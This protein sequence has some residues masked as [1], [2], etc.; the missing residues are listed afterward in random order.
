VVYALLRYGLGFGKFERQFPAAK[1]LKASYDVVIIGAG[2]H[3]V[4]TAYYLARDYGITDVAI[5]EKGYL[6]GGNAARNAT[7]T[8]QR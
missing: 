1:P 7:T 5:L 4:A 8:Q 2:G 6:G 3:G